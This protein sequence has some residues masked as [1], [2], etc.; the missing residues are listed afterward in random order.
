MKTH[1]RF[2]TDIREYYDYEF[3]NFLY[4][5]I[6]DRYDKGEIQ[7]GCK[8]KDDEFIVKNYFIDKS[9]RINVIIQFIDEQ[10]ITCQVTHV[11]YIPLIF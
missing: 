5:I 1:T 7:F 9:Y 8:I 4:K 10:N 3:K 11:F 2:K 6:K